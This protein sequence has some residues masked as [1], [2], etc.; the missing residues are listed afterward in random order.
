ME[1]NIQSFNKSVN[2]TSVDNAILDAERKYFG[3]DNRI[4]RYLKF[5]LFFFL[6]LFI[7]GLALLL[8]YSW[9]LT[10]SQFRLGLYAFLIA[11]LYWSFIL[12]YY[13]PR[14]DKKIMKF[15]KRRYHVKHASHW[16]EIV[17]SQDVSYLIRLL[18]KHKYFRD[19]TVSLL[20]LRFDERSEQARP[21][22]DP[23]LKSINTWVVA[24]LGGIL[25]SFLLEFCKIANQR[26][27]QF[28]LISLL[29]CMGVSALCLFLAN[30]DSRR[31][32]RIA[33]LLRK[34]AL[35]ASR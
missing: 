13:I 16:G 22:S 2:F 33:S 23:S 32:A 31:Y 5:T 21:N 6:A 1:K 12:G 35:E 8:A 11:T 28:L 9:F 14:F 15:L 29:V 17:E 3:A 24:I 19:R 25:S 27:F 30:R 4:Y 34:A 26:Q 7:V 10:F 20:A 18:K